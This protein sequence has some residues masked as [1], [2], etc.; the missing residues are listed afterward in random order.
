MKLDITLLY[1]GNRGGGARLT[2]DI[3]LDLESAGIFPNIVYRSDCEFAEFFD[4]TQG[5]RVALDLPQNKLR[6]LVCANFYSK[7]ICTRL[8]QELKD[9][10]NYVFI[11]PHPYQSRLLRCLSKVGKKISTTSLIHD[12]KA[13]FGELWPTRKFIKRII[14]RSSN[15]VFLSNSVQSKFRNQSNFSVSKLEALPLLKLG[16]SLLKE[17]ILVV[18]GRIRKYK[19][20]LGIFDFARQ[21]EPNYLIKIAGSGK[22]PKKK[23]PRNVSI[24]NK[25]F[26]PIEFDSLICN[27]S[28]LVSLYSEATQSGPIAIAKAYGVPI[29]TNGK[30]GT[31]E[32]LDTYSRKLLIKD[33]KVDID[34]VNK[35]VQ[36][37]RIP[38]DLSLIWPKMHI[39]QLLISKAQPT[40]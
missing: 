7:M 33:G 27:S 17:N 5:I 14:R 21:V 34:A 15:V 25:W 37:P 23:V 13:H 6:M 31:L 2:R 29:I 36:P 22:L 30:G 1:L 10:K 18:P 11:M 39:T 26:N 38:E 8:L 19:N 4:K 24:E 3:A 28:A 35:L 9:S 40:F 12:D 20:I 16:N 32:Q